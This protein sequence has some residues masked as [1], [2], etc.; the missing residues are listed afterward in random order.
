MTCLRA[1]ASSVFVG[2]IC[3]VLLS[4]LLCLRSQSCSAVSVVRYQL[5]K[6]G[7]LLFCPLITGFLVLY[8]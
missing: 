5:E 1:C 7:A 8:F 4:L 6:L 2:E 3:S